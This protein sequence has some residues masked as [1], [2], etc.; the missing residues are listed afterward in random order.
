MPRRAALRLFG[1]IVRLDR[2]G[3][4]PTMTAAEFSR[5]LAG[6]RVR[7]RG[8]RALCRLVEDRGF[9]CGQIVRMLGG[10]LQQCDWF[11]AGEAAAELLGR[12]PVGV[13]VSLSGQLVE[14]PR[15]LDLAL[16]QQDQVGAGGVE[17]PVPTLL[18]TVPHPPRMTVEL[19]GDQPASGP[20][21]HR[22]QLP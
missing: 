13:A 15:D 1:D 8:V 22:W 11:G 17:Q 18:L 12:C 3:S 6:L 20:L 7:Q 10:G 9:G 21:L 5:D 16:S 14:Y 2:L 4:T 19:T